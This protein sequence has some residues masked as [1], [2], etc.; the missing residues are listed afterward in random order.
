M[1][2][3]IMLAWRRMLRRRNEHVLLLVTICVLTAITA[4]SLSALL[5]WI[6][7]SRRESNGPEM[8]RIRLTANGP[9]LTSADLAALARRPDCRAVPS[10]SAVLYVRA[11]D[12]KYK[13]IVCSSVVANDPG[14]AEVPVLEGALDAPSPYVVLAPNLLQRLG[15]PTREVAGKLLDIRVVH[16]SSDRK[17]HWHQFPARVAAVLGDLGMDGMRMDLERMV[18]V[19]R[20]QQGH[21][22]AIHDGFPVA[23]ESRGEAGSEEPAKQVGK[24]RDDGLVA[25]THMEGDAQSGE[26]PVANVH[27]SPPLDAESIEHEGRNLAPPLDERPGASADMHAGIRTSFHPGS[28][29]AAFARSLDLAVPTGRPR[30][31]EPA[32]PADPVSLAA[33]L[34]E[35][36]AINLYV[37][38]PSQILLL[39][40]ELEGTGKYRCESKY[41]QSG[42]RIAF[43]RASGKIAIPFFVALLAV[44]AWTIFSTIGEQVKKET[45]LI[46]HW[47]SVGGRAVD[48]FT[49]YFFQGLSVSLA[50]AILGAVAAMLLVAGPGRELG[51]L[52]QV[53]ELFGRVPAWETVTVITI[54]GM[55]SALVPAL[56]AATLHLDKGLRETG[57]MG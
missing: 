6:E 20:Y 10:V 24:A 14:L 36:H 12:G 42:K 26:S 37:A 34:E 17:E 38:D 57:V 54:F 41:Y 18:Q 52:L 51:E 22:D 55:A 9:S 50:G 39:S 40:R 27:A 44:T 8:R 43:L 49:L 11:S 31:A 48:I 47:R 1:P 53:E 2:D 30:L 7:R 56:R 15:Y 33:T 16:I 35:I 25:E 19:I 29:P 3:R 23:E 28:C 45:P 5:G 32:A 13:P 21:L 46:C 4:A